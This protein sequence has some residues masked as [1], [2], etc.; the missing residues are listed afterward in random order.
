MSYLR[1]LRPEANPSD[2]S[3]SELPQSSNVIFFGANYDESFPIKNLYKALNVIRPDALLVQLSPDL[4]LQN[5][6]V[7]NLRGRK[8]DGQVDLL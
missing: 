4:L 1:L 5:F 2:S 3:E 6:E 8:D 7:D